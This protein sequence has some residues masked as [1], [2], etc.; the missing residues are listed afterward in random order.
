MQD[1]TIFI[2]GGTD[3]IGRATALTLAQQGMR[4]VI[5]GRNTAKGMAVCQQLQKQS[6]NPEIHYIPLNLASFTSVREAAGRFSQDFNRLDVLINNAGVFSSKLRLTKDGF[7]WH[8][9]INHLGHFLLTH[10]LKPL[11]LNTPAPRVVNVSSVAHYHGKINF[12]NLRGECGPA[13]FSG[14]EAYAQSKLAILLFTRELARR[15]K[16]I[17]T[18]ALH[19]GVVRTRFGNKY[20]NWGLSL[21][22]HFWKPFMCHPQRGAKTSL[23]LATAPETEGVSGAF[24]DEQQRQRDL[25]AMAGNDMLACKLWKESCRM[26]GIGS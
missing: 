25:G 17:V 7:E 2:T 21:F 20:S 8:F 23:Y 12:D 11:L 4:V 14:L 15:E 13:A 6:Q 22:W 3:G 26:T 9:G 1:K 19:P 16:R 5:A 24:F 10:L 18:N